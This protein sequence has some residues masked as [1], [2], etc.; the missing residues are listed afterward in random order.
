MNQLTH[1]YRA[2]PSARNC[3]LRICSPPLIRALGPDIELSSVIIVH[4]HHIS[5]QMPLL[6]REQS[7][8]Y[9]HIV[10]IPVYRDAWVDRR[11]F[12]I[13]RMRRQVDQSLQVL[14]VSSEGLIFPHS[15]IS[16]DLI[17]SEPKIV[18]T[19]KEHVTGPG[20]LN[21]F[22]TNPIEAPMLVYLDGT[23]T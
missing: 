19:V 7:Q 10:L 18:C 22:C 12:P 14:S 9:P 1:F 16:P 23:R 3:F 4:Y 8:A 15:S 11:S 17:T 6:S 21:S 20:V 2:N 5:S 13:A